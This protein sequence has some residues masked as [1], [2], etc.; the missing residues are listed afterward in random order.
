MQEFSH[1]IHQ[2]W[3]LTSTFVAF[4]NTPL[5]LGLSGIMG[6]LELH[7]LNFRKRKEVNERELRWAGRSPYTSFEGETFSKGIGGSFLSLI[8]WDLS[9]KVLYVQPQMKKQ[10]SC[11][12]KFTI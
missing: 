3:L 12:P 11:F 6:D 2:G 7:N 1:E 9:G 10:S 5:G 8:M 4:C